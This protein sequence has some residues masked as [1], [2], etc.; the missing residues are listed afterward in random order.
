MIA[1]LGEQAS[2]K[3]GCVGPCSSNRVSELSPRRSLSSAFPEEQLHQRPSR[4]KIG[5][6]KDASLNLVQPRES[7]R[8]WACYRARPRISET[9]SSS[10]A[11]CEWLNGHCWLRTVH[12]VVLGGL[13]DFGWRSVQSATDGNELL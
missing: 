5:R 6:Q 2:V 7:S 4:M 1:S 3:E 9:S 10:R 11:S 8:V 12:L 13:M